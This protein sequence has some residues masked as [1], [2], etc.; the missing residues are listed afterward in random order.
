MFG[1]RLT[2]RMNSWRWTL[3]LALLAVAAI[4]P[5]RA[6]GQTSTTWTGGN[7]NWSNAADWTNGVPNGNFNVFIDGG[8]PLASGVTLDISAGINNLTIDSD[9]S[10]SFNPNTALTVSGGTISNAG[11]IVINGGNATNTELILGANTTL[12]G[13]GTVTLST[14]AAGGGN[15]FLQG[16]GAT[17]T[18]T[19]NIIQGEGTIGNGSLTLVNQAGG[20]IN[21][22]STGSNG[23]I[24]SLTLNGSGGVTNAGLLEATNSGTLQIFNTVNNSGGNIAANGSAASVLLFNGSDIQGGTLNTLSGG[25]IEVAGGNTTTLDG[26]THGVLTVSK[27]STY[28]SPLST[29]TLIMGTINNN[30]NILLNGGSGTNTEMTLIGNTT[31]QG[32]GGG[33]VTLSSVSSPAGGNAYIQGNG[34]TLTNTNNIIQGDGTIGNG[35]LAVVNQSGGTID[36]NSS[37]ASGQISSLTLNGS[38]GVTN[39]G[40]LEATNSGTLQIVNTVNNS[41][42]NITANGSAASV[43]LFNGS[44]I[45]GGTLNTLSGGTI[46]TA[47]GNT[48]TLDGSSQGALTLSK[49]STYTSPLN[50]QTLILG[51]INNN[52][53]IVLNGGAA[54]NT[55][56]TLVANTTLQGAGGGTVTL[57]TISGPS[58]GNAFIQGNTFTL[59]NTNTIQGSGI[60][61]N[62]SLAV[63]NQAGGVINANSTGNNQ[64]GGLSTVLTLNGSGGVTNAGLLEATNSGVLQIQNM[65]VH[66]AAG[67]GGNIT[68]NGGTV[69]VQNSTIQGGT[70]TNNGGTLET[71]GGFGGTVLDG[72]SVAQGGQG[73]LTIN[74]TYTS[75]FNSGT[76]LFGTINNRGNIQLNG[77]IG[78]NTFLYLGTAGAPNLTLQGGGTLTL[79]TVGSP[80]GG[81][82]FIQ[83]AG[84]SFT[85][86]NLDNTIEGSGIIGNGTLGLINQA[87]INANSTGANSQVTYLDLNGSGGVTNTGLLEA[88]NSGTL[89]IFNT[90]NNSGGNITANGSTASV[91]LFYGGDI[92]GGTLNTLNG[93]TMETASGNTATLDGS[94]HG[95]LTLSKGSTYTSP[96]NTQT[97]ILG[98]INNNGGIVLD[99]GAGTNTEMTLQTNTTLQGAG[100]GTVTL[101]TASS[102]A[103]GNAFIQ[104]N[105]LTL[106]NTNNILRGAGIIGNG[107]LSLINGAGGTLLANSPGQTLLINGSGTITNNGT[108]QV[109]SG[110]ALHVQNGP[111]TNFAGTTLTGGTYNTSGTLEIDELGSSG[112]EIVTN[113][114]NITLNGPSSSFIDAAGKNALLN[115]STNAP[116][117]SFTVTGGQNFTTNSSDS[118]SGAFTNNGTL[119]VGSSSST[120]DVNG[121]LTNFNSATKTLTGGTYNVTG[122]LQFNGANIVTNSANITLTGT[123][124]QIIDQLSN[125][126]LANFATNAASASF[127]IM[128]GRNFT[129]AGNFT[130]S[131]TLIA[132]PG[133][134]FTVNGNLTN[135]NS[136][137]NTLTSGTYGVG[138]TLQFNGANIVTNA[139]NIILAG[140]GK[141]VNQTATNALTNFVNNTGSFTLQNNAS[142][143]TAGAFS[144]AATLTINSGS[145]FTVGGTGMFTQTAGKTTDNGT[146][147][148]QSS[149][150][151]SLN[152]GSLFG[153]GTINGALTSSGTI[154]PGGSS[155][156]TGILTDKGAYTQNSAGA[157]DISIGGTTAG[158]QYDQ[159]NS[160]ASAKLGGTLTTN[161]INGFVPTVG[162]SFA[163]MNFS[164]ETGT[165]ASCDG[166]AG[167]TTCPINSS[168]HFNV[169][170]NSTDVVL[171]VASGAASGPGPVSAASTVRPTYSGVAPSRLGSAVLGAAKTA[172]LSSIGRQVAINLSAT[173]TVRAFRNSTPAIGARSFVRAAA[174]GVAYSRVSPNVAASR[175][176]STLGRNRLEY[177]LDVLS[178]LGMGPRRLLGNRMSQPGSASATNFGYL[179]FGGIH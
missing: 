1:I 134:T 80:N 142:L 25:T 103:G 64:P 19:N 125:N 12:S 35:S 76:T 79:N 7:G 15:A 120:F 148:L 140:S 114:A 150:T 159:L 104:G 101:S 89:Q 30:G 90:V 156:A 119:T 52:G 131:G 8:N 14:I 166:R 9:D 66:N 69:L 157:L 87:T 102:P 59:T 2:C 81:N 61:G 82:V 100:G 97:L 138:G 126:G 16:N 34:S 160:T 122:T 36:A 153:S 158:T 37:A 39:A 62:G 28:T 144:N 46:E 74:G 118:A 63:N 175:R 149:G 163:I 115:L 29:Q 53:S 84:T 146:L 113:A 11:K 21:A 38:G 42:G 27:G 23:S 147:T 143:T 77:G 5:V 22:N 32:T 161:L 3:P 127:T 18:N 85:L 6:F 98:V 88:T 57:S 141:I 111:F 162:Q 40:L 72:R 96:L 110:S 4:H 128:G 33:T 174:R 106:T 151:L 83:A 17:L 172:P 117:S 169:T 123:S 168:E 45:Q 20:T 91:Q 178:I 54:T 24:T 154:T 51:T 10:L 67:T 129:T 71:P 56:M 139:A 105:G 167:G 58:G 78:T 132:Y 133:S 136:T 165:F 48:T 93:G 26:S 73:T 112:G 109:A 171:T 152:G 13:G 121:N 31:L 135:F 176:N 43:Q 107:S 145:T 99:G 44:D 70:L 137:T 177:N 65:T 47:G 108:M 155:T 50:T 41:G 173:A 75:D 130:N 60:I 179:T 94:S 55:E 86:T 92:Q 68:A 49:G 170:Y 116:G 124:S 164:S 95:A